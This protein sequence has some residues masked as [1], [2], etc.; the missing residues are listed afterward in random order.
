[1]KICL[2]CKRALTSAECNRIETSSAALRKASPAWSAFIGADDPNCQYLPAQA[3]CYCNDCL[4]RKRCATC[5]N[6]LTDEE[7]RISDEDYKEWA[8]RTPNY[9]YL[10]EQYL[11]GDGSIPD[12]AKLLC[13]PCRNAALRRELQYQKLDHEDTIRYTIAAIMILALMGLFSLFIAR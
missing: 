4:S 10:H 11:H 6:P 13:L 2:C 9:D 8:R 5:D 12:T 7:I 3:K 1:M